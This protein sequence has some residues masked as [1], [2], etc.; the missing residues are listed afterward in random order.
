LSKWNFAAGKREYVLEYNVADNRFIFAVTHN[1]STQVRVVAN[2]LG[3]PSLAT[4]YWV[5]ARHDSVA[6]RIEISVNNG[7]FDTT[8]QSLGVI[9]SDAAFEIGCLNSNTNFWSGSIDQTA[10]WGRVVTSG[11]LS[12]IFNA[13]SGLAYSSWDAGGGASLP[14]FIN[15]YRQQGIL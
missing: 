13:G 14:V 3:I 15:H 7:A 8:S 5:V 2:T 9:T 4:W 6:N 10:I 11:E 1:G 12:E